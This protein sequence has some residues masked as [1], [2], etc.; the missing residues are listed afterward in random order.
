MSQRLAGKV[1][2]IT[3][4]GSGL[5]RC[6]AQLFAS[7]G[8]SVVATD[9]NPERVADT[10]RL[11]TSEGGRAIAVS[12][13]TSNEA[14]VSGTIDQALLEFGKID[15][16]WSNAGVAPLGAV[17]G[18]NG[19]GGESYE[20]YPIEDWH[21]VVGVNLTGAFLCAKHA[22]APL[23]ENGGGLILFTSSSA[24][25]AAYHG[26][27]SYAAAKSGVNG[28][29]RSLS[30]DLGKWGIRVNAIAPTHGTSPN[31]TME[32]DAPVVGKSR[33]EA[34]GV[35]DKH[36]SPIPLKLDRAP[37]LLDHANMALYLASDD[38]AYV[39]GQIIST[40]DGG[41]LARVAIPFEQ[42]RQSY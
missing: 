40:G 30:L 3:G 27:A 17:P 9:I 28:L 36:A 6:A 15:V 16:V 11:I 31:F 20:D 42:D 1:V 2:V 10:T 8:A 14:D 29:T 18:K 22:I 34:G 5:G 12:G 7:E 39:S 37:S 19:A 38:A 35:W 41:T 4:A 26:V 33:Q 23:R 21:R 13:D 32:S 24:S 25:L